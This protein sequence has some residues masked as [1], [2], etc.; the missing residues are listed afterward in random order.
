MAFRQV[1]NQNH[2]IRV[3]YLTECGNEGGASV[4]YRET[5]IGIE[6]QPERQTPRRSEMH[7]K[8]IDKFSNKFISLWF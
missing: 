2:Q 6:R 8:K 7:P 1:C 5:T 4:F 3:A